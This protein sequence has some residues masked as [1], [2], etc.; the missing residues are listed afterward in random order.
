MQTY[1]INVLET[2]SVEAESEEDALERFRKDGNII[3]QDVMVV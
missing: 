2:Y 3:D 1:L